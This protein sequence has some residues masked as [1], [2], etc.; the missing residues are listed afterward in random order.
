MANG[1]AHWSVRLSPEY[2]LLLSFYE[3]QILLSLDNRLIF[4][5]YCMSN[6][7]II[8]LFFQKENRIHIAVDLCAV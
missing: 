3:Y 4:F 8:R 7:R 6:V 5:I 1:S 2:G